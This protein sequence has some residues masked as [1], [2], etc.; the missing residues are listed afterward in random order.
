MPVESWLKLH[1]LLLP[2]SGIRFGPYPFPQ[3]VFTFLWLV[4]RDCISSNYERFR[5]GSSPYHVCSLCGL[6]KETTLHILSASVIR[7][8]PI[9]RVVLSF[10][11][12][13]CIGTFSSPHYFGKFGSTETLLSS[14]THTLPWMTCSSL[15]SLGPRILLLF[16]LPSR[17]QSLGML[18]KFNGSL[19]QIGGAV[20]IQMLL[21][22]LFPVLAMWVVL[23]ARMM[24]LG[25]LNFIKLLVFPTLSKMNCG[26]YILVYL[27]HGT[28]KWSCC[29]SNWI[30]CRQ[31]TSCQDNA[32]WC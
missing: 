27:K 4:F 11:I 19:H 1:G 28:M 31:S 30:I 17:L 18:C 25:S 23:D 15:A 16:L 13:L 8:K 5:R 7:S 22:T 24:D 3:R 12:R 2:P 20:L 14:P 6:H 21:S 29:R 9:W 10:R 32:G 26:A